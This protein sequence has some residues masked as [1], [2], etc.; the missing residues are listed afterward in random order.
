LESFK[1]IL[2]V[3]LRIALAAAFTSFAYWK[4][5]G[6]IPAVCSAP[7]WGVL[8]AK[9]ILEGLAGYYSWAKKQPYIPWQGRYYEFESIH[10]RVFEDDVGHLWFCDK[11]VL[12][13]LGQSVSK[14]Y[15]I[16]YAESDY[17]EIPGE[18]LMGFSEN[19]VILVVS[20]IR[21]PSAGK[22]KFWLEREVLAPHHKRREMAGLQ[23]SVRHQ[24]NDPFR[25]VGERKA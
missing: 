17:R 4:M 3:V 9:P 21:H 22:F 19:I 11:D 7:I 2:S 24:E 1:A 20:R 6:L 5:G 23:S 16:A 15:R 14:T 13:A 25:P 12:Q 10:I 18:R 8:L